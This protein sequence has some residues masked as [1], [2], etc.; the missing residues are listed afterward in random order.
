[1]YLVAKDL[2]W[3]SGSSSMLTS[4]YLQG[5]Q[6]PQTPMTAATHPA[7]PLHL[8]A[9][10]A[11]ATAPPATTHH[12]TSRSRRPASARLRLRRQRRPPRKRRPRRPGLP[13]G[14]KLQSPDGRQAEGTTAGRQRG[15]QTGMQVAGC[16][17][18]HIMCLSS[19]SFTLFDSLSDISAMSYC[20][21]KF[22]FVTP[23]LVSSLHHDRSL[24]Q[25]RAA[26]QQVATAER[27]QRG[28]LLKRLPWAQCQPVLYW[29]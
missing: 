21:L 5:A 1:M 20:C 16:V 24:R 10:V 4:C 29:P 9:A 28:V 27:C 25:Q 18:L 22:S 23:H 2:Q 8:T 11:A 6:P 13:G 15:G 14:R 12:P 3:S 26:A 19:S 17:I 7:T